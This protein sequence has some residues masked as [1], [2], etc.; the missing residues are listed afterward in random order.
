MWKLLKIIKTVLNLH[1][2]IKLIIF[3]RFSIVILTPPKLHFFSD[4]LFINFCANFADLTNHSGIN[5]DPLS[6]SR[7]LKNKSK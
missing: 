1:L 2:F 6:L 4:Y 5:P 3:I 7:S